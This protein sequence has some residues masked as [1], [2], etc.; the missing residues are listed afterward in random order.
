MRTNTHMTVLV[1]FETVMSVFLGTSKLWK[2]AKYFQLL[3]WKVHGKICTLDLTKRYIGYCNSTIKV[4]S[5]R[6]N[7]TESD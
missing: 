4:A 1:S 7:N 2:T 3:L 5:R 6:L